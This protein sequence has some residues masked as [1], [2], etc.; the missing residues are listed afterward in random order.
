[1]RGI[2][3]GLVLVVSGAVFALSTPGSGSA[4]NEDLVITGVTLIDGTGAPPRPGTT[5]IINDGRIIAVAPD[6]EAEASPGASSMDATGKSLRRAKRGV[7]CNP[8]L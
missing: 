5:I 4:Q 2:A 1:M 6:S 7:K 8:S 3:S